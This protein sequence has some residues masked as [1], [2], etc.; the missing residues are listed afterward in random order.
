[1]RYTYLKDGENEKRNFAEY[2]QNYDSIK[3]GIEKRIN[4]LLSGNLYFKNDA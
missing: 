2:R 1:M 4:E 3:T